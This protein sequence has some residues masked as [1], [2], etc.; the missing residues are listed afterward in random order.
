M[1]ITHS[2]IMVN[3]GSYCQ[4]HYALDTECVREYVCKCYRTFH[5]INSLEQW[6]LFW[7]NFNRGWNVFLRSWG[8]YCQTKSFKCPLSVYEL[9]Q[10]DSR[11]LLNPSTSSWPSLSFVWHPVCII[12][13]LSWNY[14]IKVS[15]RTLTLSHVIKISDPS[16]QLINW[17]AF[18]F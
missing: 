14:M 3:K 1:T 8:N 6:K 15:R 16:S 2:F 9:T 10:K 13:W 5:L 12:V 11:A 17:F 7:G 4:S 18:V